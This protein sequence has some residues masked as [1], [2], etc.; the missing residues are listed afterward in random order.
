MKEIDDNRRL[1]FHWNLENSIHII[2]IFF[3]LQY[4]NLL[5]YILQGM[6]RLLFLKTVQ[7][8]FHMSHWNEIIKVKCLPGLLLS[9][10]ETE[11]FILL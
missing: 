6:Q 3:L 1:Q 7:G 10:N 2:I 5:A 11:F 8:F 9:H 4:I